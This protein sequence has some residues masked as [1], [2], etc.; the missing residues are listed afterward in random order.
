MGQ[1]CDAGC[2]IVFTAKQ[3]TITLANSTLLTGQHDPTTK[4]W[5]LSLP[6][7]LPTTPPSHIA[8]AAI[9][10]VMPMDLVAFAHA[11]LF[12]FALS[13]LVI[14]LDKGFL[15][16][17][18]GFTPLLLCKHPTQSISVIKGHLDQSR[19]NQRSTK[20]TPNPTPMP[21]EL[22]SKPTLEP[23]DDIMP[24]STTPNECTHFCYTAI[25]EPT[26]QVYTDQTG[27]FA[28]YTIQPRQ[29]L[30]AYLL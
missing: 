27:W 17:F 4:L 16:N 22:M 15:T 24:T 1:F 5:H 19:K 14:A 3:V 9:R 25:M 26:G 2:T 20:L 18:P 6:T 8:H 11:A 13:T 30:F 7:S 28:C 21:T 23:N 10:S 29:Q 12:S